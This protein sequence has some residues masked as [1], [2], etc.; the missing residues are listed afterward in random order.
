MD[1]FYFLDRMTIEVLTTTFITSV[2]NEDGDSRGSNVKRL[3]FSVRRNSLPDTVQKE[4]APNLLPSNISDQ[5]RVLN[6]RNPFEVCGD[7]TV[8][9]RCRYNEVWLL[10]YALH[11]FRG[12]KK[13]V[14]AGNV[15]RPPHFYAV[16]P[17]PLLGSGWPV[18][19]DLHVRKA[20][21]A[22]AQPI[23][24]NFVHRIPPRSF[25]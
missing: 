1:G 12:H 15:R 21:R 9:V 19:N 25:D 7:K 23:R 24:L 10:K 2:F 6:L 14:I 4:Q 22:P 13:R 16:S 3:I 17:R 8:P 18:V 20:P 11:T 5:L